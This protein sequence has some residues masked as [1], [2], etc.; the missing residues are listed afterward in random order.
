MPDIRQRIRNRNPTI[1]VRNKFFVEKC[2]LRKITFITRLTNLKIMKKML[3]KVGNFAFGCGLLISSLTAEA[4]LP[5][6]Q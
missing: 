3:L 2:L 1:F 6:G 4:Q 5:T